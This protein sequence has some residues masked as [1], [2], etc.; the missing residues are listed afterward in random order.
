MRRSLGYV[1]FGV[2]AY[3]VFMVASVPAQFV[4]AHL[5]TQLAPLRISEAQGTVWSGTANQVSVG[6]LHFDKA[7]W[8][9]RPLALLTGR[10][11]SNV[12][13]E[14]KGLYVTGRTGISLGGT[15]YVKQA[16]GEIPADLVDLFLPL[17]GVNLK[18]QL[19]ATLESMAFDGQR[20][21]SAAGTIV[22]Q[23]AGVASPTAMELGDLE[24]TFKP[25]GDQI[26]INVADKQGPVRIEGLATIQP[27]GKYNFRGT[28]VPRPNADPQLVNGL[29]LLG[30][31][32]PGN[33]IEVRYSG[34]L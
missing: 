10:L 14:S 17:R 18:G 22:W 26:Q 6:S 21:T 19:F 30:R 5:Q 2:G 3:L 33:A 25:K 4:F 31:S 34:I 23:E 32:G 8:G 12:S 28:F 16:K 1:G 11:E 24:F 7:S 27:D 9:F 13:V 20:L 29:K 15:R